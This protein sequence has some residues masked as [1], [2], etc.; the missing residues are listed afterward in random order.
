MNKWEDAIE[1]DPHLV[2]E[3]P[4]CKQITDFILDEISKKYTIKNKKRTKQV[5]QQVIINLL[6]SHQN[7]LPIKYSRDKNDYVA[8]KR[9]GQIYFKYERLIQVI[10][11]LVELG[12][13]DHKMGFFDRVKNIGRKSRMLAS[14]KLL[15]LFGERY[16]PDDYSVTAKCP[17]TEVIELKDDKKNRIGY[18]KTRS[19][20]DMKKFL[21]RYNTFINTQDIK[22][23]APKETEINLRALNKLRRDII[24]GA[25][26]ITKFKLVNKNNMPIEFDE[27]LYEVVQEKFRCSNCIIKAEEIKSSELIKI[28]KD[29][30]ND[31]IDLYPLY[32]G[33]DYEIGKYVYHVSKHKCINVCNK[34]FINYI[35]SI[36]HTLL[37]GKPKKERKDKLLQK[38]SLADFELDS[39]NFKI[40][41]EYHHRVF[42][43][44]SFKLG[45]RFF[46]GIHLELPKELRACIKINQE[47]TVEPD[48]SA[49]HIRML[50]NLEGIDYRDDPYLAIAENEEQRKIFKSILLVIINAPTEIKGIRAVRKKVRKELFKQGIYFD[51]T[52]KSIISTIDKFKDQHKPI[53]GYLNTGIGLKLQNLDSRVAENVLKTMTKEMIP[54]LPVHDSFI[55]PAKNEEF[56]KEVMIESYRKVM[57]GFTPVIG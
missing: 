48:F 12:Y 55:V 13:I 47:P 24:K 3:Y 33:I 53:A 34:Y 37:R 27:G 16:I 17:P 32:L 54:C 39:L 21:R 51:I 14:N 40:N 20:A 26:E 19:V 57:K 43:Q 7:G 41:H 44:S 29:D 23:C 18:K 5:L 1:I 36:T 38:M 30:Y 25:I 8:D 9:Y 35:S 22:V 50:Y 4:E 49:M 11:W 42:N 15:Y 46:G 52:D 56:L 45:G 6:V 10:D 28:N 2:S 31:E